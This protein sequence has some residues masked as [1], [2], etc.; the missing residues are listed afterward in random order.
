MRG[1]AFRLLRYMAGAVDA[2]V[3]LLSSKHADVAI[4]RA[5]ERDVVN[6]DTEK[7]QAAQLLRAY[8][9]RDAAHF[10]G[11][12]VALLVALAR[13]SDA[14]KTVSIEILCELLLLNQRVVMENGGVPV[15]VA[16]VLECESRLQVE[17]VSSPS[18]F[19]FVPQ[20]GL[21]LLSR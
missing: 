17:A 21:G 10:P 13:S 4:I 7:L 3:P 5:M 16:A 8:V 2:V 6:T 9:K 1:A 20:P 15:I 12:L 14:Y 19:F 18:S 11:S